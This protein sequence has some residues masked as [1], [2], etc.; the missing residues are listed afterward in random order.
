MAEVA[1]V[2]AIVSSVAATGTALAGASAAQRTGRIQMQQAQQQAQAY[3]EQRQ[4]VAQQA[5]REESDRLVQL[6]RTLG[7]VDALRGARGLSADSV[8]AS[9]LASENQSQAARDL[10]TI[11][12]N[13][14][15]E[16][17]VL[18]LAG[19]RALLSGEAAQTEAGNRALA[20]YG[21]A[22]QSGATLVNQGYKFLA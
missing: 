8:G 3:A 17:R 11:T 7:A 18:G 22:F 10:D 16:A 14:E 13:S 19:S 21:Q 1:A 9:V 4:Q 5:E 20:G 2:A 6:R 12:L 15:R